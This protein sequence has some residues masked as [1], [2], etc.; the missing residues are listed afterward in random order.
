M[1]LQYLRDSWRTCTWLSQCYSGPF[2]T[3]NDIGAGVNCRITPLIYTLSKMVAWLNLV[4]HQIIVL[5]IIWFCC[6]RLN[7][8]HWLW[9]ARTY[10]VVLIKLLVYCF[11]P[12]D[13]FVY[14][15][16]KYFQFFPGNQE[17]FFLSV[18]VR[19]HVRLCFLVVSSY[20]TRCW[21]AQNRVWVEIMTSFYLKMHLIWLKSLPSKIFAHDV[22]T[23]KN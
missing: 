11:I 5:W 21:K 3:N 4:S 2:S 1:Y 16:S 6:L 7:L 14:S 22:R 8:L 12:P 10:D 18:Y 17:F 9:Y 15:N 23:D 13:E 20:L 19:A